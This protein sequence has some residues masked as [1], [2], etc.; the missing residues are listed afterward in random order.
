MNFLRCQDVVAEAAKERRERELEH[1]RNMEDLLE[2][3]RLKKQRQVRILCSVDS[4]A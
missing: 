4:R 3:K 1:E 2:A